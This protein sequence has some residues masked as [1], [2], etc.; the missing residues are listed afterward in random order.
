VSIAIRQRPKLLGMEMQLH[1]SPF[2]GL[3]QMMA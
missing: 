3:L 1:G 2:D